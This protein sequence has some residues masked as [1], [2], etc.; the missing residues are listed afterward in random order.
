MSGE[1]RI[2]T[3]WRRTGARRLRPGLFGPVAE[4]QEQRQ[5]GRTDGPGSRFDNLAAITTAPMGK[6]FPA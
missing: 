4:Y 2:C 6:E 1:I 5:T 3:A